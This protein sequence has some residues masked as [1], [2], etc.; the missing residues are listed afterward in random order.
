MSLV[1]L[2]D[3]KYNLGEYAYSLFLFAAITASAIAFVLV[4]RE[5]DTEKT[6]LQVKK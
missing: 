6:V 3:A 2:S 1:K 5:E 4:G